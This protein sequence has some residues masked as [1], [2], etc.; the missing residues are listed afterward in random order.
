MKSQAAV[1]VHSRWCPLQRRNESLC[2]SPLNLVIQACGWPR[3]LR[4]QLVRVA[5]AD[6]ALRV[7]V[8][9][10]LA[11]AACSRRSPST[12]GATIDNRAGDDRSLASATA[13]GVEVMPSPGAPARRSLCGD[14]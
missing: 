14:S 2:I 10:G 6:I 1:R 8:A 11:R 7:R 9:H 5:P 12:R 13:D 3:S 4:L